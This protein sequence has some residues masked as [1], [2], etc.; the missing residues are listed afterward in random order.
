LVTTTHKD[1]DLAD[2]S[3]AMRGVFMGMMFVGFMHLYMGY[4]QP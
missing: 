2:V 3:K 1:Y 4:T